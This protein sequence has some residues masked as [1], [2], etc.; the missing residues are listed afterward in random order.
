LIIN[1]NHLE[2]FIM[3]FGAKFVFKLLAKYAFK[4]ILENSKKPFI[5]SFCIPVQNICRIFSWSLKQSCRGLNSKQLSFLGYF[6]KMFFS[7][8]KCDLKLLFEIYLKIEFGKHSFHL[9][10]PRA[11]H[12]AHWPKPARSFSRASRAAPALLLPAHHGFPGP[13]PCCATSPS[14]ARGHA[15]PRSGIRCRVVATCRRRRPDGAQWPLSR[16]HSS[17]FKPTA[18]PR[19]PHSSILFAPSQQQQPS[20]R[21]AF[22]PCQP[23]IGHHIFAS[24]PPRHRAARARTRLPW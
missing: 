22:R 4:N 3:Q 21:R 14:P 7:C 12:P 8:S 19:L 23:T 13:G 24:A 17:V 15:R 20:N 1:A 16:A 10:G 2:I 18:V 5:F 6:Q 11:S 9:T